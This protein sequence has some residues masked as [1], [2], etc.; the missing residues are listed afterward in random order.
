MSERLF[1]TIKE[2]AA[3][4]GV[5][6]VTMWRWIKGRHRNCPPYRRLGRRMIRIPRDE[7]DRWIEGEK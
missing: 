2:A 4:I 7:F 6:P 3:V 5:H 1:I